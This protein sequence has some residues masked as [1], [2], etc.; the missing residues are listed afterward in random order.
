MVDKAIDSRPK[1]RFSRGDLLALAA[2]AAILAA[3]VVFLLNGRKGSTCLITANGSSVSYSLSENR[4]IDL[5]SNGYSLTVEIKDGQVFV[6]ESDCPD[7][8]CVRTGKI[9]KTGQEIIC[10]PAQVVIEVT[11]GGSGEDFII[12]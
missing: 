9:S 6:T 12:G 3:S 11:G 2:V 10:V 1:K 5:V 8:V 7:R 4:R